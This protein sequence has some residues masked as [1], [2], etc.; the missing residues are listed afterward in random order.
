L[1]LFLQKK[2]TLSF[3]G[4]VTE[5]Q[6]S[7]LAPLRNP[8]FRAIWL[9]TQV[10]SLGWLIQTVAIAW[11]MATIS[12]SDIMVA[13]VQAAT[14]F[15]AFLL[16]VFAGALADNYSRRHVLLTGRAIF[17]LAYAVLAL[18]LALGLAGPWTILALILVAG[19]GAALIDPAWQ[20]SVG[21]IVQRH[22]IPAAVS[23]ISL[24]FNT[25]RSVGPALG[26]I[27]VAAFGP[28]FALVLSVISYAFPVAVLLRTKWTVQ[29]PGAPRKPILAA[30]HDGLRFT[31][32]TP[33]ILAAT[34][35]GTF[36]GAAGISVLALLPLIVRDTLSGTAVA[37]GIM[38]AC[39]GI[40]ACAGGVFNAQIR[41]ALR[42]HA[43]FA[44]A[45]AATALCCLALA[46]TSSLTVAGA[47]LA[48][49]GLGWVTGWNTLSVG[50]Q[51]SSPRWIVGRTISIYYGAT[52]GGL[53]L[54]S[55]LWGAIAQGFG[56]PTAMAA[57]G[58]AMLL[59]AAAGL[60]FPL[61][62][63]NPAE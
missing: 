21:D 45:C 13:L 63:S 35:Q 16:S 6:P 49:G 58:I 20:A 52:F 42:P 8:V 29:P 2:K 31:A 47:A 19:C 14:T 25:V 37:F 12:P 36:Y 41:R 5:P 23:L 30:M 22:E 50:V 11:L 48:L 32:R 24:G 15:P 33:A 43:M 26:G 46:I 39:F 44:G 51:M 56:L 10:S 28:L 18:L 27:I 54:G 34:V 55:W 7:A 40:G 53:T 57:S 59:V 62:E 17:T 60:V 38:M 4:A 3:E 9:S 61:R 1:L